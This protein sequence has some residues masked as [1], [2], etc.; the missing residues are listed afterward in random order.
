MS[1]V[2][3]PKLLLRLACRLLGLNRTPDHSR[4]DQLQEK[5]SLAMSAY[6]FQ[7]LN[8]IPPDILDAFQATAEPDEIIL[9]P[10]LSPLLWPLHNMEI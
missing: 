4:K 8:K 7:C 3:L 9:D 1:H 2:Q 5:L 6:S 10:V